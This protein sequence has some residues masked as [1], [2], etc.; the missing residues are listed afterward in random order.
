MPLAGVVIGLGERYKNWINLATSNPDT[1]KTSR[2]RDNDLD[3]QGV[4][5][6][7]LKSNEL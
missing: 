3:V 7:C 2:F 6:G 5:L 4:L 1:A